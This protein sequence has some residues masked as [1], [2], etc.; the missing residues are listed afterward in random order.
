MTF[1]L[2][3]NTIDKTIVRESLQ[4][5]NSNIQHG[6]T[7]EQNRETNSTKNKTGNIGEHLAN[8]L[9]YYGE[10]SIILKGRVWMH[11]HIECV[12]IHIIHVI[13]D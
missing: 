2:T 11:T 9:P 13:P 10:D 1:V 5:G 12:L 8:L 4:T 7:C 6:P 3:P